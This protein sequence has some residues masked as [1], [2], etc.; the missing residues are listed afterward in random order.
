MFGTF[1][2]VKKIA[3]VSFVI[4]FAAIPALATNGMNM[5]GFGA[6]MSAMGGVAQGMSGDVNLAFAN[7]AVLATFDGQQV[8]GGIGFL[9]PAVSFE[10]DLNTIDGESKVFPL[11][12]LGYV[13]GLGDSPWAFGVSFYAQGGMGATYEDVKHNIFRNYMDGQPVHAFVPQQYHSQ[14]AIMRF[15]PSVAYNFSDNLRAGLGLQVSYAMLEMQM[16]YSLPP[17]DLAGDTGF[18]MTFGQMFAAPMD[19]GGLG[20]DEVTA[21]ADMSDAATGIGFSGV[22]GFQYDVNEDL[23]LGLSYTSQTDIT[24]EGDATMDMNAQFGNAYEL[25]VM[26]AMAG[27][28]SQPDAM[29]AVNTQLGGMGI[30]M[31]LGMA[32][33]YDAEIEFAWPQQFGVG[34]AFQATDDLLIGIDVGWINWSATMESFKMTFSGGTNDNINAMMGTPDGTIELEMP[35]EWDDQVVI[36]IGAEYMVND[37][38]AMRGGFNYASNPVPEETLIPIF[39]AVVESHITLGF[40]YGLTDNLGVDFGYEY[41]LANSLDVTNSSIANE[42]DGSTSELGENV[43]HLTFRYSF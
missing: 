31:S 10:N 21:Y 32:D 14:I 29:N 28:L 43:V 33:A 8:G 30:D 19:Q 18:G 22:A 2:L 36:A 41:V 35:L 23:T 11:P 4:A 40:G 13:N 42:Y 17:S 1:R 20:Y 24:F 16:P 12:S 3:I 5:I 9:L 26:G 39:P 37:R 25:M 15:A 6:R 34:A 27:G 38:F 7:P